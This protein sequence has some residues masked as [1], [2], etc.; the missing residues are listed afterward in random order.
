MDRPSCVRACADAPAG[1]SRCS[2]AVPVMHDCRPPCRPRSLRRRHHGPPRLPRLRAVLS[3]A[4]L[5]VVA[6]PAS[7]CPGTAALRTSCSAPRRAAG[8]RASNGAPSSSPGPAASCRPPR[9]L[10]SSAKG[11]RQPT[12]TNL[13]TNSC[14]RRRPCPGLPLPTH[15]S[16][17]RSACRGCARPGLHMP[18]STHPAAPKVQRPSPRM[19]TVFAPIICL[20]FS[21][22]PPAA[23]PDAPRHLFSVTRLAEHRPW[24]CLASMLYP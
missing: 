6:V 13:D 4:F 3:S 15:F 14:P 2:P 21:T 7:R 5:L 24:L 10:A 12:R 18:P 17:S 23:G 19:P 1:I 16:V 20:A 9:L 8:C 11:A 22:L